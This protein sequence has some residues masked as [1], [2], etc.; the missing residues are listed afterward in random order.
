MKK[1]D[2][3]VDTETTGF[4]HV[5]NP[6][7]EDAIVELGIAYRFRGKIEKI[8]WVCNPGKRFFENGRAA[9]AF[10]VNNISLDDIVAAPSDKV[11][12]KTAKTLLDSLGNV[13]LHSYNIP[14]DKP[15][16]EKKPWNFGKYQWGKDVMDLAHDF[17]D[18][19][20]DYKIGLKRTLER[21]RIVPIGE[22]HRAATDAVSAMMA[23]EV[24]LSLR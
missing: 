15:F 2:V 1:I 21:L 13:V 20:Q 12:S 24:I 8:G 10:S 19:P 23:Y 6:Q 3:F 9:Q 11:I 14:F 17:F 7:R 4:G 16:L 22:P 5:A 18:L